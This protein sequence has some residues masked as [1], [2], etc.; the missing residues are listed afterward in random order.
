[1]TWRWGYRPSSGPKLLNSLH[2]LVYYYN[3]VAT[4]APFHP[5]YCSK[6]KEIWTSESQG[7][8]VEMLPLTIFLLQ[9]SEEEVNMATEVTGN[10]SDWGV[11]IGPWT[12][13]NHVQCHQTTKPLCT[14][15]S[16]QQMRITITTAHRELIVFWDKVL[17]LR[18]ASNPGSFWHNIWSIGILHNAQHTYEFF[19]NEKSF[20]HLK[21]SPFY[22]AM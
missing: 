20:S 14:F 6:H 5:E 16:V 8:E 7:Y 9:T 1:M 19:E 21:F 4:F 18:V 10:S 3:S 12:T 17:Q 22:R 15:V 2:P 13:P 11:D